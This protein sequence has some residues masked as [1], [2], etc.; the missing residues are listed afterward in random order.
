MI[1]KYNACNSMLIKNLKVSGLLSF[2]PEGIDLDLRDLNVLTGPNGSGKSNLLEVL[3]FLKASPSSL[4]RLTR[5]GS[6]LRNVFWTDGRRS[7]GLATIGASVAHNDRLLIHTMAFIQ[8]HEYLNLSEETILASSQRVKETYFAY[9][10]MSGLAVVRDGVGAEQKFGYNDLDQEE[11]ILSQVKDPGGRYP[12]LKA[13]QASYGSLQFYRDWSFGPS[14]PLRRSQPSDLMSSL[15]SESAENLPLIISGMRGGVKKD[16]V[17]RLREL[18]SG[19]EGIDTT[20]KGGLVEVF[21]DE[22]NG[23]SIPASRL[24]D[25]TLRYLSLLAILLNPDPPALVAI[26]EPELGLHPDVLPHLGKLIKEA[27]SRMQL[28]VTTHSQV[29]LDSFSTSPEDVVVCSR[30]PQGSIFERLSAEKL[31]IWLKDHTLGE[32]WNMGE[33]GGNRW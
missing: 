28:I 29:L 32:L 1:I 27:S 31:G 18:I 24:S 14:S 26:E 5:P 4:K 8:I 7:G 9:E 16:L 17:H 11:S 21:L 6:G 20:V 15:L 25:G 33:I 12:Y 2:G 10:Q 23:R 30:G 13:L 22:G 3:S 19:V